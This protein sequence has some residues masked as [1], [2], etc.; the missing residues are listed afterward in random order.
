MQNFRPQCPSFED[1]FLVWGH[2]ATGFFGLTHRTGHT[3]DQALH[4]FLF[5]PLGSP[6]VPHWLFML[7]SLSPA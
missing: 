6:S 1:L 4:L 2:V 5:G 7:N 3:R